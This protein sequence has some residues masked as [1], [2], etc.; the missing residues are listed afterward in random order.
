MPHLTELSAILATLDP[1]LL[2]GE[3]VFCSLPQSK[4]SDAFRFDPIASIEER[5]GLSVVLRRETA[6]ANSL[7]FAVVLRC[8][9]LNVCSDLAAVGLTSVFATRLAA[10]RISANVIAGFHHDHL[11]IPSPDAEN[12]MQLLRAIQA[13][14][15][16]DRGSGQDV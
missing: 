5:E 8:I 12:A 1:E 16:S 10:H 6:E 7:G 9:T 2:P 14:S 15:M 4:L 11:F 13:E 3:F